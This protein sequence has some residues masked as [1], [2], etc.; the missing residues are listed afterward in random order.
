[1]PARPEHRARVDEQPASGAL[2]FV[3]VVNVPS[4]VVNAGRRKVLAADAADVLLESLR[5]VLL[6]RRVELEDLDPRFGGERLGVDR[7]EVLA[8]ESVGPPRDPRDPRTG[9]GV[10]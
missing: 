5:Q 6:D 4:R 8:V 9:R 7:P 3:G 2:A 10:D 1:G